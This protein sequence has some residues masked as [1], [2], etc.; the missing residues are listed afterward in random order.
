L[1]GFGRF[2]V[3]GVVAAALALPGMALARTETVKLTVHS[4]TRTGSATVHDGGTTVVD[5]ATIGLK[6]PSGGRS[7]LFTLTTPGG[8]SAYTLGIPSFLAT[9][10]SWLVPGSWVGS[11]ASTVALAMY[12]EGPG[13]GKSGARNKTSDYARIVQFN[14]K[15]DKTSDTLGLGYAPLRVGRTSFAINQFFKNDGS[16]VSVSGPQY[17][18]SQLFDVVPGSPGNLLA[19]PNAKQA[20]VVLVSAFRG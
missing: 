12:A 6:L 1:V 19:S 2:A 17:K 18:P 20:F 16:Q 7:A 14:E 5:H 11:R 4:T 10:G 9:G 3:G 8:K 13:A 15:T